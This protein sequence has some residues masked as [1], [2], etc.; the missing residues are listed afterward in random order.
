MDKYQIKALALSVLTASQFVLPT[1]VLDH[2]IPEAQDGVANLKSIGDVLVHGHVARH[3]Q[4]ANGYDFNPV[5]E[6][7]KMKV[8]ITL[9]ATK[10]YL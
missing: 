9:A 5:F 1:A 6:A 3:A 4:T 7:V 8:I 10:L 2:Q